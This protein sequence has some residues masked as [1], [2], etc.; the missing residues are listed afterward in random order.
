M[1]KGTVTRR[2]PLPGE[3]V[4]GGRGVLIPF[5]PADQVAN[6][7]SGKPPPTAS[8][9]LPPEGKAASEAP[10]LTEVEAHHHSEHTLTASSSDKPEEPD[11]SPG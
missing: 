8:P 6:Q 1:G 2:D 3:T 4:F 5:R 9:V 11:G 7:T 10:Q